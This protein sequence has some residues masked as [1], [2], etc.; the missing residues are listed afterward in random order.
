[1]GDMNVVSNCW[2]STAAKDGRYFFTTSGGEGGRHSI[3]ALNNDH[4]VKVS[5]AARSSRN[6]F[7]RAS[8]GGP[9]RVWTD[10]PNR[11][12]HG[13]GHHGCTTVTY[14]VEFK[15]RSVIKTKPVLIAYGNFSPP[16][17]VVNAT[18]TRKPAELPAKEIII[19]RRFRSRNNYYLR[20]VTKRLSTVPFP[21]GV[22]VVCVPRRVR[23]NRYTKNTLPR[24]GTIVVREGGC[25]TSSRR[26][27]S[28]IPTNSSLPLFNLLF[29]RLH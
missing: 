28:R 15:R 26:L 8:E 10:N 13:Y 2:P 25:Y 1:M 12:I 3:A 29:T 20:A 17:R 14:G 16:G 6:E 21:T 19:E 18:Y 27:N 9:R 22:V 24:H 4:C 7:G 23:P 11:S 5:A